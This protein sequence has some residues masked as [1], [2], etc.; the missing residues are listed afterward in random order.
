MGDILDNHIAV[1]VLGISHKTASVEIRELVSLNEEEQRSIIEH[2]KSDFNINGI[3]VNG[4]LI[5]STC[6]RTE[7]YIS[8]EKVEVIFPAIKQMLASYKKCPHYTNENVTY[9]KTGSDA[10]RHFFNVICGID[11]QIVGELQITGQVKDCYNFAH[12]LEATDA[13]LNKLYNFGMQVKKKVRNET[14]LSDGTVSV[15]FAGV[16]LARKIFNDLTD[17]RILLVGA[18]KTAELAAFHFLENNV[19]T[20]NVANRTLKK[21]EELADKFGGRSYTLDSL[22]EALE[23]SDIVISATSSDEYVIDKDM[24]K[25][26]TKKIYYDSIF[27]IDLAIPRDID[28]KVEDLN[29]VY[30]YNLDDLNGIVEQN[31]EKRRKEIPRASKIVDEYLHEFQSWASTNS[32]ATIISKLKNHLET[33]SNNELARLRKQFPDNGYQKELDNYTQNIINKLVRQHMKSLKKNAGDPEKYKQHIEL[34]Y[35]LYEIDIDK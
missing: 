6:N 30:L 18:G 23:V 25:E 24:M 13:I 27:L 5:L 3:E 33:I 28:P 35:N 11:S 32:M 22:P 9:E 34:I 14:I 17:K 26:I 8:A 7:F 15:S 16:E 31:L 10:V 2:I 21:A 12:H 29:N 1:G 19:K 4:I 20:I